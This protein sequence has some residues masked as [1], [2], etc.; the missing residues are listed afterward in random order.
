VITSSIYGL[1]VTAI[2][3]QALDRKMKVVIV[4]AGAA[5]LVT[6]KSLLEAASPAFPFDPIILEQENDIGGT[7][8][9]RSYE[10]LISNPSD[11]RE[12]TH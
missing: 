5:G 6:C 4:G 11:C 3:T 12:V 7:F 8:R 1:L 10:V 9:Y 2:C